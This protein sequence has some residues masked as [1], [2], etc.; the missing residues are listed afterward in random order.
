MLFHH[1]YFSVGI[2]AV[3]GA[4][5]VMRSLH[6]IYGVFAR[7]S[8]SITLG[9][10]YASTMLTDWSAILGVFQS[11]MQVKVLCIGSGLESTRTLDLLLRLISVCVFI[12][13]CTRFI[14]I[15][16]RTFTA[17]AVAAVK[18]TQSSRI[19]FSLNG[20]FNS[21]YSWISMNDTHGRL[22]HI[23]PVFISDAGPNCRRLFLPS[24][25]S[26]NP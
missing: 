23:W 15:N 18:S 4:A 13:S 19:L 6:L 26:S 12:D 1:A 24:I 5:V 2:L 21:I 8:A 16:V 25:G 22:S 11:P 14:S 9:W 3:T 20:Q 10:V 7:R 17:V